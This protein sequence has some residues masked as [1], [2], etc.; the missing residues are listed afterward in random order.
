MILTLVLPESVVEYDFV[1]SI[2]RIA[3]DNP[4]GMELT[5]E[6]RG[7]KQHGQTWKTTLKL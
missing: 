6:L 2:A 3:G 7:R 4:L 1:K 5:D